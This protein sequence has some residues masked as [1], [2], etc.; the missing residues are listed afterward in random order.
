VLSI[1]VP[2]ETPVALDSDA[3]FQLPA[4][5]ELV[6]RIHY[7]KTWEYERVAMTDRSAIGVYFAPAA[8]PALHALTLAG[9]TDA[10][11]AGE[12]GVSFT[13][14]LEQNVRALAIYPDR[15]L[16]AGDVHV[17]AIRPDGSR[18]E[19]IRFRPQPDWSRR[20]WF[21]RPFELPRGTKI[22]VSATFA[23]AVRLLPPGA[24]APPPP[25]DPSAVRL[26]LDVVPGN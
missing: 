5:A 15:A 2:G 12:H 8:A 11:Q 22:D 18:L 3:A 7:K 16:I 26:T 9:P 4:G 19:V 25:P 24:G 6:V 17:Q 1:W 20:Y 10:A 21:A 13:R 14:V 23:D